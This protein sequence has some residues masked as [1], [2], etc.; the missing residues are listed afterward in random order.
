[1]AGPLAA[2]VDGRLAHDPHF[3]AKRHQCPADVALFDTLPGWTVHVA[4]HAAEVDQLLRS[5]VASSGNVYIRLSD[6]SNARP[7]LSGS[8]VLRRGSD[9][10][11]LVLAVGPLLDNV[12]DATSG[13]DVTICHLTRIRP[14]PDELVASIAAG[15]IVLV[16]P[17]LAGT[18]AAQ[19]ARAFRASPHRLLCLGV[20]NPELHRYGSPG[21]HERAHGLDPAGI[22]RSLAGFL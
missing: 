20:S 22:R 11:P 19:V 18:S 21:E 15:D 16:E 6:R 13:L 2:L 17:Y 12:V 3:N 14:F 7:A 9:G 10:A 5:A 1:M 4:G 8:E